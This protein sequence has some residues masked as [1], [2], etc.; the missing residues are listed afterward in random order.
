MANK[1]KK[2]R[3]KVVSARNKK[4][5]KKVGGAF[6]SSNSAVAPRPKA[7]PPPRPGSSAA[8]VAS[9]HGP[10]LAAALPTTHIQSQNSSIM[11]DF[12]RLVAENNAVTTAE[13]RLKRYK[14][15]LATATPPRNTG[16]SNHRKMVLNRLTKNRNNAITKLRTPFTPSHVNTSASASASPQAPT[17]PQSA[18][19]VPSTPAN[20]A[21]PVRSSWW[22]SFGS[23]PAAKTASAAPTNPTVPIFNSSSRVE[24]IDRLKKAIESMG[25]IDELTQLFNSVQEKIVILGQPNTGRNADLKKDMEDIK[26]LLAEIRR[27]AE[28]ARTRRNTPAVQQVASAVD[29]A[30]N[31]TTP[32]PASASAA[33]NAQVNGRNSP[34]PEEQEA[35]AGLGFTAENLER[36][37]EQNAQNAQN[38]TSFNDAPVATV[39]INP[40]NTIENPLMVAQRAATN[41]TKAAGEARNAAVQAEAVEVAGNVSQS[42]GRQANLNQ[43]IKNTINASNSAK[44]FANIAVASLERVK[45]AKMNMELENMNM[46]PNTASVKAENLVNVTNVGK[47]AAENLNLNNVYNVKNT[48]ANSLGKQLNNSASLSNNAS[49][50]VSNPMRYM[51]ASNMKVANNKNKINTT[52]KK[53]LNSYRP[54]GMRNKLLKRGRTMRNKKAPE[55]IIENDVNEPNA[56]T[57]IAETG[58]LNMNNVYK[59]KDNRGNVLGKQLNN[60]SSLSNNASLGIRNPMMNMNASNIKVANNRNK[61]DTTVKKGL[62]SYRPSGMRNKL[63]KRGKTMKNRK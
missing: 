4:T 9:A 32:A 36:H 30:I 44:K 47:Y 20:T 29:A 39:E 7:S 5:L 48:S 49:L 40:G 42:G 18:A 41:A 21:V 35:A 37:S 43:A 60:S 6:F 22:P 46:E 53:G 28:E 63:L 16:E 13:E 26:N 1:S 25:K 24:I 23:A 14:N 62:N 17:V 2:S 61:I 38:S 12:E 34:T 51:N 59:V 31:A 50:G 56:E 58:N 57:N 54:S 3:R 19:P 52:V 11:N 15:G 55:E 33:T 8:A 27:I 10:L 45:K